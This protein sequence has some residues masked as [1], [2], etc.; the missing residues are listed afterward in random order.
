MCIFERMLA[1]RWLLWL[2][3]RGSADEALLLAHLQLLRP[4]LQRLQRST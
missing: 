3:R 4:R 1:W 2:W